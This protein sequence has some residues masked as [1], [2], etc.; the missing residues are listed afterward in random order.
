MTTHEIARFYHSLGFNVIPWMHRSKSTALVSGWKQYR[1]FKQTS[2]IVDGLFRDKDCGIA[3]LTGEISGITVFDDDHKDGVQRIK[4]GVIARSGGG[5]FHH[6]FKYDKRF[7]SSV[8]Q[9]LG[10]D[11]RNDGTLVF[12][13][14]MIH[15]TSGKTYKFIN[16]IEDLR[17][18]TEVPTDDPLINSLLSA[19]PRQDRKAEDAKVALEGYGKYFNIKGIGSRDFTIKDFCR[20]LWMKNH[21]RKEIEWLALH[22]NSTFEI[23]MTKE[24]VLE[25][26]RSTFDGLGERLDTTIGLVRRT[27]PTEEAP[28]MIFESA[29]EASERSQRETREYVELPEIGVPILS[30]YFKFKKKSLIVLAGDT[31]MGKTPFCTHFAARYALTGKKVLFAPI[32]T[33]SGYVSQ[34][35]KDDIGNE[36]IDNVKFLTFADGMGNIDTFYKGV[37]KQFESDHYDLVILD[38]IHFIN[39]MPDEKSEDETIAHISETLRK[40]AAKFD[41]C[42]FASAQVNK[43][44]TSRYPNKHDIRFGRKLVQD[45]SIVMVIHKKAIKMDRDFGSEDSVYESNGVLILDKNRMTHVTRMIPF[46]VQDKKLILDWKIKSV[47]QDLRAIMA[48]ETQIPF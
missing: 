18:L 2:E 48:P 36:L 39:A 29:V 20:L 32:E 44:D 6:F 3:I 4:S 25:K 45:A 14:P 15:E 12:V 40:I 23:P 33:G 43:P 10:M 46:D 34:I 47:N 8:N 19:T 35:M 16:G 30:K 38:H 24:K 26:V 27:L 11:I 41:T 21:T 17:N 37:E 5:G 13:Y 9:E 22:Q 28:E 42:V 31:G 7:E 1:T